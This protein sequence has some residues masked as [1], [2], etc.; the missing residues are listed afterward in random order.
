MP[1]Y[2]RFSQPL[3][4]LTRPLRSRQHMFHRRETYR[5]VSTLPCFTLDNKICVVTGYTASSVQVIPN[6]QPDTLHQRI[7]RPRPTNSHCLLPLR[8]PRCSGRPLPLLCSKV[9][10]YHNRR[11]HLRRPP[12]PK[13]TSLRMQ[14]R[15]RISS[16]RHF[17]SDC[18]RFRQ[19]RCHVYECRHHRW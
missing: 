17:C 9:N 3:R 12:N 14:H 6:P 19:S 11:S 13:P 5:R 16:Q 7:P 8:R 15:R 4:L 18:Q 10:L 2:V 1:P